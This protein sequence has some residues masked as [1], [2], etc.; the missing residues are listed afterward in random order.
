MPDPDYLDYGMPQILPEDEDNSSA[1]KE[2]RKL[3]TRALDEAIARRTKIWED[4][5]PEPQPKW[6]QRLAAGAV[7]GLAG[8]ANSSGRMRHP[9]DVSGATQEIL[10]PGHRRRLQDWMGQVETAEAGVKGEEERQQAQMR[11]LQAQTMAENAAS[12]AEQRRA[13]AEDRKAAREDRLQAR[14]MQPG[15]EEIREEAPLETTVPSTVPGLPGQKVSVAKPQKQYRTTFEQGGKRYGVRSPEEMAAEQAKIA[16]AEWP[17]I[18]EEMAQKM[19]LPHLAG[20]KVPPNKY[21]DFVKLVVPSTA[22]PKAVTGHWSESDRGDVTFT[23]TPSNATGPVTFKGIGKARQT[24]A[25]MIVTGGMTPEQARRTRGLQ[26]DFDRSPTVKVYTDIRASLDAMKDAASTGDSVSDI[27]LMRMFAKLTD[28]TTGVRE[29]EYRALQGAQGA[30]EKLRL[31]TSGKWVEGEKLTPAIRQAFVRMAQKVHDNRV[32]QINSIMNTYR[33]RA[34]QAGVDPGSI[35]GDL[36]E[37]IQSGAA[38]EPAKQPVK[39]QP[40]VGDTVNVGGKKVKIKK[41]YPDG[42]FDVE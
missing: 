27:T 9:I 7:G 18:T 35:F 16:Q 25:S 37:L 5:P 29:E 14:I 38:Q 30:L 3:D 33:M 23:P 41:I 4:R 6:W 22:A 11:Q 15:V 40:K 21:S 2:P 19:G 42:T 24:P 8:Y 26:Q 17:E 12:L 34:E 39:Q 28:P 36:P 13:I 10:A 20:R 1:F 31:L 32:K